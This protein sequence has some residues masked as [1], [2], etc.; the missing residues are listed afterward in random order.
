MDSNQ[1]QV[2]HRRLGCT[3]LLVAIFALY[4]ILYALRV[5]QHGEIFGDWYS[6]AVILQVGSAVIWAIVFIACFIGL[7]QQQRWAWRY[8]PL[9][10]MAF[11]MFRVMRYTVFAQA[12]Y[13]RQRL[14]FIVAL[15]IILLATPFFMFLRG[16]SEP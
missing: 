2:P 7:W 5:L 13:D 11:V 8:S 6:S 4:Q 15:T 9:M 10:L 14:L 16:R 1:S 12:D 3:S